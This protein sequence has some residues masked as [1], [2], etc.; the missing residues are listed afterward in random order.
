MSYPIRILF[1][2][3]GDRYYLR[4]VYSYPCNDITIEQE[5]TNRKISFDEYGSGYPSVM[6][7]SERPHTITK[8]KIY[9]LSNKLEDYSDRLISEYHDSIIKLNEIIKNHYATV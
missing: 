2:K 5:D 9:P 8:L 7:A 3:K 4:R 1:I 6:L